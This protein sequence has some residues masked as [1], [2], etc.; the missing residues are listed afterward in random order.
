MAIITFSLVVNR[1]I[2]N[3]SVTTKKCFKKVLLESTNSKDDMTGCQEGKEIRL[4][5][6]H[7]TNKKM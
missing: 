2:L 5:M 3:K 4:S 7:F 6:D 1:V